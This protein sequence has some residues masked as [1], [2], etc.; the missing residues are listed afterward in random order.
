MQETGRGYSP[1]IKELPEHERPR[2]RLQAY[3]PNVL[4]TPELIAII[5][6]TGA[7]GENAVALAT[8]LIGH[9]GGLPG[10][11][12][13]S[14]EE[15]ASLHGIGLAKATELKAAFELGIRLAAS[16]DDFKPVVRG[17][18]DAAG[19]VLTEMSLLAEEELRTLIL[20]TKNQVLTIHRV[21][22]GTVNSAPMRAAEV[23]REAVR[24]NAPSIVVV[25][26]HPSGDPTPSDEDV[27]ATEQ[28]R[29][30]GQVLGIDLLDHLIVAGGRF[31]SLRQR[32]LGFK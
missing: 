15:L 14:V 2:E 28:L 31:I 8:R 24:R 1:S 5:M 10:L 17:P 19:L 9:F 25:H 7:R 16:V 30:A 18:N 20:N 22:R 23:F 12:R 26:N 11:A 29:Q 13:A 32:G 27:N 21:Y 6:R 4:S 3:G